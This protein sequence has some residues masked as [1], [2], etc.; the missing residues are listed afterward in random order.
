LYQNGRLSASRAG[1][2]AIGK[3]PAHKFTR[4][5]DFRRLA[6]L[7]RDFCATF[8]GPRLSFAAGK[9]KI[10]LIWTPYQLFLKNGSYLSGAPRFVRL[11]GLPTSVL[12]KH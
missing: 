9:A 3:A 2:E 1:D 10:S 4:A 5:N 12:Y 11:K 8:F 6:A 7:L